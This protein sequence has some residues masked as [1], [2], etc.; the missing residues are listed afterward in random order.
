MFVVWTYDESTGNLTATR[1]QGD[2]CFS[3]ETYRALEDLDRARSIVKSHPYRDITERLKEAA[4]EAGMTRVD[5][6]PPERRIPKYPDIGKYVGI[7]ASCSRLLTQAELDKITRNNP[8]SDVLFSVGSNLRGVHRGPEIDI[9]KL[10][11]EFSAAAPGCVFTMSNTDVNVIARDG[12]VELF[13]YEPYEGLDLSLMLRG[14]IECRIPTVRHFFKIYFEHP[15]SV[16]DERN[17]LFDYRRL[18]KRYTS[19]FPVNSRTSISMVHDKDL[20]KLLSDAR[21]FFE[22]NYGHLGPEIT[23][24]SERPKKGGTRFWLFDTAPFF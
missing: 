13:G 20:E 14:V 12:A 9:Y 8:A 10:A 24:D 7:Y 15:T 3:T 4:D 2:Q 11:A 16:E 18:T 6:T 19:G 23:W 5:D 22:A 21:A 1:Y 17:L